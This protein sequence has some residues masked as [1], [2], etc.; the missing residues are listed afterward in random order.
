MYIS[1]SREDSVNMLREDMNDNLFQNWGWNANPF[2]LKIDPKLFVGYDAQV[3][4]ALNHI[5]NHHKIALVTGN[6]GAGKTTFL[7]WL[8]SQ[9]DSH[10]LYVHKPPV[11]PEEFVDIFVDIFGL[12]FFERLFRRKPTLYNLPNY[13]N[14]KLKGNHLLLLMDEAHEANKEVLEWTRV[15]V[16]QIDSGSLIL[17]GLPVFEDK[18]KG[19]ETLNQRITTRITLNSLSKSE[20]SELIQKRIESVGGKDHIPF[21]DDAIE[22]I[23]QR[24]GG[25]PR[26]VLKLS[27]RLVSTAL[28]KNLQNIDSSLIEEEHKEIP[29]PEKFEEPKVTFMPRPPSEEQIRNLPYKQRKIIELLSKKDWLTPTAVIEDLGFQGYATKTMQ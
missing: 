17:A 16:D 12:S 25:F 22:K 2:V 14:R 28:E 8:E 11:K 24:T 19:I 15:L 29:A 4:A 26:E 20:T 3:R 21:T 18:L 9:Y 7:K 10:K 1:S 5:S 13:V 6:T 27:D 23:Y